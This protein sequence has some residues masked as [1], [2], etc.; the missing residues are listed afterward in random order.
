VFYFWLIAA[1][2]SS[3]LMSENTKNQACGLTRKSPMI[4]LMFLLL[5][6]KLTLLPFILSY[7]TPEFEVRKQHVWKWIHGR[8]CMDGTGVRCLVICALALF[9]SILLT[10]WKSPLLSFVCFLVYIICY[11]ISFLGLYWS[12][13][14]EHLQIRK[15]KEN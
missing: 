15:L 4:G 11:T 14:E 1:C 12:L 7:F 6:S 8:S 10:R 5:F 13:K 2:T 9:I 3:K